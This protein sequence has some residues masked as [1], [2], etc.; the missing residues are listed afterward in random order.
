MD[1]YEA[2]AAP[3]KQILPSLTDDQ[4]LELFDLIEESYCRHCGRE[5]DGVCHCTNDE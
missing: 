1:D 4:R 3:I 2:L 5:L